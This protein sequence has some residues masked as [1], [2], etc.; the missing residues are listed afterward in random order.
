VEHYSQ[1]E[2]RAPKGLN[3]P[4]STVVDFLYRTLVLFKSK[5]DLLTK[6]N[7]LQG[8]VEF[9]T[10]MI[11]QEAISHNKEVHSTEDYKILILGTSRLKN[12]DIYKTAETLS[13]ISRNNIEILS[14]YQKNKRFDIKTLQYSTKYDGILIGPIAH[15]ITKLGSYNSVIQLLKDNE[16]YP[17]FVEIRCNSN[18]LKITKTSLK[19]SLEK[20]IVKISPPMSIGVHA[21]PYNRKNQVLL[22]NGGCRESVDWYQGRNGRKVINSLRTS[23]LWGGLKIRMFPRTAKN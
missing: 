19:K 12:L 2:F 8:Q 15:K 13:G 1:N 21:D 16:G 17:P 3:F 23:A 7:R 6:I 18:Q 10:H 20:L 14:D 9:M 22:G 11:D 5:R 4:Y